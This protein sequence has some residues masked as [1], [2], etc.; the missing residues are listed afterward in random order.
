MGVAMI[1]LTDGDGCVDNN[2]KMVVVAMLIMTDVG[3]VAM[4]I[5]TR[6]WWLR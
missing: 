5:M 3:V 1:I 4:I 6:W 2:D